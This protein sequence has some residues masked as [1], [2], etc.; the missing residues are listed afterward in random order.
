MNEKIWIVTY[1]IPYEGGSVDK[2]FAT[3]SAANAYA[4]QMERQARERGYSGIGSYKVEDWAV[5]DE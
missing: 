1:E 4:A 2:V 3:E 5:H